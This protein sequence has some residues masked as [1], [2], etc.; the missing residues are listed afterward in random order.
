[1]DVLSLQKLILTLTPRKEKLETD[2]K[3]LHQERADKVAELGRPV[4]ALEGALK[5]LRIESDSL[6]AQIT[7]RKK[8]LEGLQN[9]HVSL[10]EHHGRQIGEKKQEAADLDTAIAFKEKEL[11]RLEASFAAKSVEVQD[12]IKQIQTAQF[13]LT[14]YQKTILLVSNQEKELIVSLRNKVAIEKKLDIRIKEL[15]RTHHIMVGDILT[16]RNKRLWVRHK[17]RTGMNKALDVQIEKK[18]KKL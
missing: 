14:N 12:L 7:V 16:E 3:R 10:H 1:M 11:E 6:S 13:E 4:P 5:L 2:I 18:R 15:K 9:L 17:Q 8:E